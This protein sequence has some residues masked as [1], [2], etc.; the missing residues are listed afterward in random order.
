MKM[1]ESDIFQETVSPD[2]QASSKMKVSKSD[3]F[4]ET[5]SSDIQASSKMKASESDNF[6][7]IVQAFK[8]SMTECI[9]T[10]SNCTQVETDDLR[11]KKQLIDKVTNIRLEF[12]MF[13]EKSVDYCTKLSSYIVDLKGVIDLVADETI[14][15]EDIIEELKSLSDETKDYDAIS[16]DLFKQLMN[17]VGEFVDFKGESKPHKDEIEKKIAEIKVELKNAE[18][19]KQKGEKLYDKIKPKLWMRVLAVGITGCYGAI[20]G[21]EI[22]VICA[23]LYLSADYLDGNNAA[24]QKTI[25]NALVES[26]NDKNNLKEEKTGLIKYLSDLTEAFA[27]IAISLSK[28]NI[29]WNEQRKILPNILNKLDKAE[30]G[31]RINTL[32]VKLISG[33]LEILKSSISVISDCNYAI[34]EMLM[35]DR[36]SN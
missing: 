25:I 22:A 32:Q 10:F 23:I 19:K 34:L 26:I 28:F 9:R 30:K 7:E 5:A 13:A 24:R 6:Q 12:R 4:Q 27:E 14:H 33:H 16:Q 36:I 20:L 1:V 8:T 15:K 21:P 17:I 31:N 11:I 18:N 2:I 3:I 29:W 35:R